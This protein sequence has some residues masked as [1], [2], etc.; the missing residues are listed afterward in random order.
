MCPI[1]S[2]NGIASERTFMWTTRHESPDRDESP[3]RER[4]GHHQHTESRA[5][6]RSREQAHS[7][8]RTTSSEGHSMSD[9]NRV[10][11]GQG[12]ARPAQPNSRTTPMLLREAP[13]SHP[14]PRRQDSR[15]VLMMSAPHGRA[16][17]AGVLRPNTTPLNP[18]QLTSD[19][20]HARDLPELLCLHQA[21]GARFNGFH[22]AA[23]WSRFKKLSRGELGGLSNRLEPVCEQTVRMLPELDARQVAN[24]AHAFAKSRLVGGGPYQGVWMALEEVARRRLGDFKE[25]ELSNTAWAF[26][27]AGFKAPALFDIISAEVLRR[28]LDDFNEQNLSNTA[29]AFAKVG[30]EAPALFDIISAEVVRRGLGDFKEQN[31]SNTAWAFAKAGRAAPALFESISAE[32]VRRGLGD[33]NEQELSNT[34]WAFAAAGFKA[35]ALFDIISAEVLRRGLG[36]FKE[37]ELSNTA[38]AFAKVG[39]EAPDLFD[40]ISAEVVRRGLGDFN[41]QDLSN[42]AWAFAVLN[43]P[44]A[45]KLF[46][47][48]SFTTRCAHLETSFSLEH[49]S[50]LHQWSL[51][52]EERGALWPGLPRPLRQACRSAFVD[53]EGQPSQLQSDV[54]HEIRSRGATVE[55]EHH[56]EASGYSIDVLATLKD[57]RRVAVEVD[58]PSHFL[59]S[60][61]QPTGATLL[62]RRQLRYFDWHLESV[63]YW[64]WDSGSKELHWLS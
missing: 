39:R 59:G 21:H 42:M 15:A 52:R 28:G 57:G 8:R 13:P 60:S 11:L 49:L 38:W 53:D 16:N 58:G 40:N 61:H 63:L 43:P 35:P 54:V 24:I 36:D 10:N 6:N 30:R 31:L 64:E 55:E 20:G 48:A 9:Y 33:F 17:S 47:M 12:R 26:A 7:Y 37:Q 1:R 18:R 50:Q 4:F 23:F 14:L 46:S 32:M 45:D 41:A 29:W 5:R 34:A 27:A 3:D 25:Q 56:C 22:V 2:R 44:S 62:K 19:L 51:W